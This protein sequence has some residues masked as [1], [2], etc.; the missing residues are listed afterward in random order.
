MEF[1]I[2]SCRGR[3]ADIKAL[4]DESDELEVGHAF[5]IVTDQASRRE[6]F[7][8]KAIGLRFLDRMP[9]RI[10]LLPHVA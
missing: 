8:C 10:A 7:N 6:K 5:Q 9:R 4:V 1:C 2:A 3:L